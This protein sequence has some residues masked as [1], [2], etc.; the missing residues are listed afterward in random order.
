MKLM[1]LSV[2]KIKSEVIFGKEEYSRSNEFKRKKND[3]ARA[4]G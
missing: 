3:H 2:K 1:S 4:F